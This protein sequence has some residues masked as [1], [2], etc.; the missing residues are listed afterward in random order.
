[1]TSKLIMISGCR[2]G[3]KDLKI[4]RAPRK[5]YGLEVRHEYNYVCF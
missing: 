3:T 2:L 4:K 5:S 1:M